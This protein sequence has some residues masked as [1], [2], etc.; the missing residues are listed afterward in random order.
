MFMSE[1]LQV[2][3]GSKGI[4]LQP[5]TAYHQ[6]TDGQTEIRNKEVVTIVRA[7]ALAADHWVKKLPEI[8]LKLNSRYN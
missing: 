6:Q 5:S 2:W 7:S 8:Q 4:L 3:A 1:H